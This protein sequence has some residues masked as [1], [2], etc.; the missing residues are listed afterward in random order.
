MPSAPHPP[1]PARAKLLL[2]FASVYF[3]WGS[4]FLA[5]RFAI[6]GIPP[7]LMA[8]MRFITAGGI[9]FLWRRLL[10]GERPSRGQWPAAALVGALL[11]MGG[12]GAVV[13][14]EQR[15]ASG[16]TALVQAVIPL[17]MVLLDATHRRGAPLGGRVMTGI[18]LGIAGI[19]LLVQPSRLLGGGRIEPLGAAVLFV[20]GLCWA[21][22][23]LVSR[24]LKLPGSPGLAAGMQMMVGGVILLTAGMLTG[25]A[26]RLDPA[27]LTP[28][29]A[30]ALCYLIVFGSVVTFTAYTW[31]LSV[32]P[33]ARVSTYAYVNPVVAV[34]LGW[35]VAGEPITARTLLATALIVGAV[36]TIV[37]T[38]SRAGEVRRGARAI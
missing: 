20:G 27:A 4:T 29:S 21:T 10:H 14:S 34:I 33:P 31:L 28:R 24:H 25:E 22:G 3:V 26:A 38:R 30:G 17:W 12:N 19:A 16:L 15:V 23:S 7:F 37:T 36:A 8:G 35:A 2:A 1:G 11:F 5:I 18:A 6:E 32:V 9:L 13:W